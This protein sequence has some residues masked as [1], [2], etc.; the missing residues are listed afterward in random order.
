MTVK[1]AY[2]PLHAA[3]LPAA[4]A[5]GLLL[6]ACSAQPIYPE[7]AG[8]EKLN[9]VEWR[10]ERHPV[11]FDLGNTTPAPGEIAELD[12]FV[13]PYLNDSAVRVYVDAAPARSEERRVGKEGV[14]T[15]TYRGSPD[16]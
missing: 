7:A 14:S 2:R 13:Q 5:A 1:H 3:I 4:I 11:R 10:M 12:R 15:C 9:R 16:N 8:I 6:G